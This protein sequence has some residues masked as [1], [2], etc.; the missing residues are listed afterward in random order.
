MFSL[1][2]VPV[3]VMI[4]V[5]FFQLKT[6]SAVQ[7]W[8][9][10]VYME[11]IGIMACNLTNNSSPSHPPKHTHTHTKKVGKKKAKNKY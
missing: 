4:L 6:G 11:S 8:V 1:V 9:R 7:N 5:T 3:V 2:V 10:L